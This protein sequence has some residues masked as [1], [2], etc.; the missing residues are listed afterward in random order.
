MTAIVVGTVHDPSN[1]TADAG[2]L[3]LPPWPDAAVVIDELDEV[4]RGV[5]ARH[6]HT[7]AAVTGGRSRWPG[8]NM[9]GH[10]D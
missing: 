3:G 6:T 1:G 5:A 4:I 10:N 7:P 9:S 2:R 8:R